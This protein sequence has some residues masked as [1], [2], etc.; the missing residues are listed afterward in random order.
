MNLMSAEFDLRPFRLTS[1]FRRLKAYIF[2]APFKD[3][4]SNRD[5]SFLSN[6]PATKYVLSES[7]NAGFFCGWA[8]ISE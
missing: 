7:N 1:V 8:W 2:S 3:I 5:K 6:R 4:H